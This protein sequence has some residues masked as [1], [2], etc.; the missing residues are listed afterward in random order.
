MAGGPSKNDLTQN[1]TWNSQ[2]P[3]TGQAPQMGNTPQIGYQGAFGQPGNF[4]G[5]MPSMGK[6]PPAG[7]QVPGQMNNAAQNYAGVPAN[8]AP[9]QQQQSGMMGHQGQ[10]GFNNWGRGQETVKQAPI[11]LAAAPPQRYQHQG[12]GRFTGGDALGNESS[13]VMPNQFYLR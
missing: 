6:A 2:A 11:S 4:G 8:Q 12:Q 13:L 1:P 5:G 9:P 3:N 10:G 7:S